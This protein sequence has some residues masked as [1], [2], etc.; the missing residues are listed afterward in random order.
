[1]LKSAQDPKLGRAGGET[2]GNWENL[3][4]WECKAFQLAVFQEAQMLVPMSILMLCKRVDC[5]GQNYVEQ[6]QLRALTHHDGCTP[7]IAAVDMRNY[8]IGGG[9]FAA[10]AFAFAG[11]NRSSF[12][13]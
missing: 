2:K 9:H 12:A 7:A 6:C 3:R 5:A 13:K 4:F 8:L 1:V 11:F 10:S